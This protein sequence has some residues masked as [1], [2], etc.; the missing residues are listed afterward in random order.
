MSGHMDETCDQAVVMG[1]S[2]AGLLAARVL[3]ERFERVV[4]I[5][6]DRCRRS[7]STAG[8]YRTAGTCMA[9]TRA[10]ARSSMSC[11]PASPK[12]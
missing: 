9:C 3:S 7:V 1:S 5:E 8:G 11:F 2:M 12:R 4:V 10:A 6:R